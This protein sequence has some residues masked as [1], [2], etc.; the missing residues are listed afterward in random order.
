MKFLVI[1]RISVQSMNAVAGM[2][3]GGIP[4]VAALG[5]IHN[6]D[7]KINQ[8]KN[9]NGIHLVGCTIACHCVNLHTFYNDKKILKFTQSRSTNYLHGVSNDKKSSLASI[10]E[11]GKMRATLSLVIQY[12]GELPYDKTA[13]T[14][15]L[16]QQCFLQRF[17]GG[18]ITDIGG[19][20]CY[21][22]NG[23]ED[24][25]LLKKLI[26]LL[27]PSFVLYSRHKDLASGQGSS[28]ERLIQNIELKYTARPKHQLIDKH[29][30]ESNADLYTIWLDYLAKPYKK[31]HIPQEITAYFDEIP[32]QKN[33]TTQELLV[34]WR[35]YQNPTAKTDADW[36]LLSKPTSGY[37]VPI[38]CGYKSISPLYPSGTVEATR[39]STTDV[40]FAE[41]V[42]TLGEWRGLHRIKTLD[43]LAC[44]IWRYHYEDHWYLAHQSIASSPPDGDDNLIDEYDF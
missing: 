30:E 36:S 21:R 19:V 13:F 8:H 39:D 38:V 4:P 1:S 12:E 3:Y 28:L 5:Y 20:D 27:M 40:C 11:E 32:S 14:D 33:K 25:N 37:I 6:L 42:Y 16:K 44:S 34:E 2:T 7:R 23:N 24:K 9:Y 43:E 29:L 26:R 10:V 17:S 15:W 41:A 35:S 22:F 31:T 18:T